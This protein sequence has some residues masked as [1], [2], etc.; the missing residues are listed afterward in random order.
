MKSLIL[1]LAL[2]I[3]S[4]A[5]AS[6]SMLSDEDQ[7]WFVASNIAIFTDWQTTRDLARRVD[8]GYRE[9]GP[10]ARQLIGSQPTAARVDAFIAARFLINYYIACKTENSD[11]KHLYLVI[12][13]TSHGLATVNN[14]NVGLRIRF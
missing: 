5:S 13:T 8:E 3:S 12:T 1:A 7:K 2:L 6:C 9:I 14:Y 11:F 4:S 10:I